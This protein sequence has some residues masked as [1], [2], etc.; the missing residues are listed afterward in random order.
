M[1]QRLIPCRKFCVSSIHPAET[2]PLILAIGIIIQGLVFAGVQ[3]MGL[4]ALTTSG[5]E[6]I[7]QFMWPG[8][9]ASSTRKDS[10]L[11]S[12]ALFIV[13]YIQLV[14][15][16]ECTFRSLQK[17]PFQA[18]GKYDVTICGGVII[19][20]LIVTWIPSHIFKEPDVC[21]ASLIWFITRYGKLGFIMLTTIAG[22][23]IISVLTI[24]IRLSTVNM[25]DQHQ[26]I[27]ASRMVYYLVLGIVSLVSLSISHPTSLC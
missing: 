13:P 9:S 21:F 11:T 26:R 18:R 2:F 25:I 3:G 8:M 5:C 14:F 24:F 6:N 19:V 1:G 20:M 23:L 22:V 7:A 16:L 15:G 4:E 12:K 27:A 10:S 17:M